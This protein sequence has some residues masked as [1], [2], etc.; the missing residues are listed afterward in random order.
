MTASSSTIAASI[1]IA[2]VGVIGLGQMG[3][4]I[5]VNLH[6]AGHLRAAWDIAPI[7]R[8]H[9]PLAKV[10][11]MPARDMAAQCDVIIFVVPTSKEIAANLDGPDG[12]LA[13]NRPGQIIVDLT[14]SDPARTRQLAQAAQAKGRTYLDAGMT[15]GASGADAGT[16]TLMIGGD[17][18]ALDRVRPVLATL[19]R[20]LFHV[21]PSGAGHTL[22][23]IH[24]MIVH[25]NFL[26]ACEGARLA[27]RAG[28]DLAA[29]IDVLNAGNAR[30]FITERR[31]PD[32]ILSGK[33]DGR[34]TVSNLAKDLAMAAAHA[35]QH[36]HAAPYTHL[37]AGLLKR[38]V[39]AGLSADDFTTLYPAIDRLIDS[40]D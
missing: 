38:A 23:L 35:D 15:G 10:A 17:A 19:A 37:T 8:T 20:K 9:A 12:I 2:P 3:R 22:K 29:V 27:E 28:L 26:A 4:G 34:S 5:A 21:G 11:M 33:F 6:R 32:H 1:P 30:S 18:A 7:A 36:G 13:V 25:T 40:P 39:D 31:F 24:N 14:T 16:L